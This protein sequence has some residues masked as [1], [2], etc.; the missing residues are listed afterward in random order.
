[1][2]LCYFHIKFEFIY[3]T[4]KFPSENEITLNALVYMSFQIASGMKYLSSH[5]FVHR[6]LAARN[7]L[8]GVDYTVKILDFGMSKTSIYRVNTTVELVDKKFYQSVGWHVSVSLA[9][10][11]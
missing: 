8:V 11:Q 6:D 4:E 10:F 9:S 1:M 7:I 5:K 2:I 3:E